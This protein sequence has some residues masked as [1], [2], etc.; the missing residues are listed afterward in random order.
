MGEV[1]V[2]DMGDIEDRRRARANLRAAYKDAFARLAQILF[3]EDPIGISFEDNTDEYE[4]EAGTILPKLRSCAT[5]DDITA[6]VHLEFV[7]WFDSDIAGPREN[8]RRT[9][10]R[11]WAEM[12]SWK[13]P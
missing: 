13:L 11:I 3:E 2:T 9:A 8:Y 6:A 12:P 1:T 4:A 5:V 7:R 10:E